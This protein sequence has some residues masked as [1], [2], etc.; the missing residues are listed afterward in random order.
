MA[1]ISS[2]T[3]SSAA[4][5]TACTG[6]S[7]TDGNVSADAITTASTCE[8]CP[9][10]SFVKTAAND[11]YGAVCE[12]CPI[13]SSTDSPTRS[14]EG[15]VECKCFDSHAA[16]LTN[17]HHTCVCDDDYAGTVATTKGAVSGCL[18]CPAK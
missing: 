8:W 1:E 13:N 2:K 11:I 16:Y 9:K 15:V 4:I 3:N 17:E 7:T 12:T 10:G 18:P 6:G 5:C 14:S